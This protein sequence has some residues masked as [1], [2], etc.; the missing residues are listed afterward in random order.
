MGVKVSLLDVKHPEW[1]QNRSTRED[2]AVLYQGGSALRQVLARYLFRRP[3][4]LSEV[5]ASRLEAFRYT[6]ML[7]SCVDFYVSAA[8]DQAPQIQTKA[9]DEWTDFMNDAD[10]RGRAF[11][12]LFRDVLL[13]MILFQKVYVVVDLP[14][15]PEVP[16]E[17]LESER[18]AGQTRPHLTVYDPTQCINWGE[19]NGKLSWV[20]F[21]TRTI[22]TEPLAAPKTVDRWFL[23]E[24]GG[25][26]TWSR[27]VPNDE[28]RTPDDA[29]AEEGPAGSWTWTP[30]GRPPVV[31][32]EGPADSWMTGRALDSVVDHLNSS[33]VLKWALRM[34]CL[35][36]PV[37][38]SDAD[39]DVTLSEQGFIKLPQGSEYKWSEPEGKSFS[40]LADDVQRDVEAVHRAF[41]ML[42]QART[43]AAT[44]AAQS[45]ASKREDS[46]PS[47]K[48]L[49]MFGDILRRKMKE[50][51]DL[52]SHMSGRD[53]VWEV[54]G[55]EFDDPNAKQSEITEAKEALALKVP[56][57]TFEEEV[58]SKVVNVV[59][60][61]LEEQKLANIM[62][63]IKSASSTAE[64]ELALKQPQRGPVASAPPPQ[65]RGGKR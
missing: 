18:K 4:E 2:A 46:A 26:R 48:I 7:A 16:F 10:R 57:K 33:G 31:V 3:K 5:Y 32:V 34:A 24:P 36:M 56:S 27:V 35:A 25:Y 9:L 53:D 63:E 51:L 39:I 64:A 50:T 41:Y 28:T 55:M 52:A 30:T 58:F 29:E 20:M 61:D 1:I 49:G 62:T 17:D 21:T 11:V 43:T 22:E 38:I 59:L 15:A 13:R 60:P 54:A 12:E 14:A 6:N 8:F 19:K 37:V 45:A 42:A 44:P 40:H 23:F 47:L 65:R